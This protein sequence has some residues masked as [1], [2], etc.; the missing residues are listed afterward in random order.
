MLYDLKIRQSYHGNGGREG[1]KFKLYNTKGKK[2]GELKD[3]PV[4]C[5]RGDVVELNG[6]YYMISRVYNSINPREEKSEVIYYE[7]TKYQFKPKFTL[8]MI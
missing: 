5:N 6:S 8:E 7:L 1:Y 4:K 2:L 3:L